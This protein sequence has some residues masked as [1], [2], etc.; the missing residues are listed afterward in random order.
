MDKETHKEVLQKF[1]RLDKPKRKAPA[2]NTKPEKIE[3]RQKRSVNSGERQPPVKK[4]FKGPSSKEI[5]KEVVETSS[6]EKESFHSDGDS[7]DNIVSNTG[8]LDR[9]ADLD[10][11]GSFASDDDSNWEVPVEAQTWRSYYLNR[12][13]STNVR[14]HY[15]ANFHKFLLHVGGSLSQEQ[16]LIHVRQVRQVHKILEHLDPGGSDLAC[17][18]RNQSLD[19]WD[20]FASPMMQSKALTGNTMKLYIRSLEMFLKFIWSNLF[21]KVP[22]PSEQKFKIVKLLERLPNYRSTIHCRTASQSTTRKVEETFSRMTTDDLQNLENTELTKSAIKLIGVSTEG[23]VVDM[24]EF[25]LVCDYLMVTMPIENGSQPGLLETAKL[26]RFKRATYVEAEEKYTLLVDEHKTTRHQGP[27]ELTMDKRIYSYVKIY[28]YYIRPAFVESAAD[29]LFINTRGQHFQKGTIGKHVPEFFKKA[30]IRCDIR[31]TPTRVCKFYETA[32]NQSLN[33]RDQQLVADHLNHQIKTARQ[34]Y[35]DKVNA[36]K[37]SRAHRVLKSLVHPQSSVTITKAASTEE[38]TQEQTQPDEEDQNVQQEESTEDEEDLQVA[39]L[40][41]EE[42]VVVMSI[43]N[44][45]ISMGRILT[46][47]EVRHKMKSEKALRKFVVDAGKVKKIADFV[48]Y[49]T[50]TV[51]QTA[52]TN[53]PDETEEQTSL[54]VSSGHGEWNCN[55]VE[56]IN[57]FFAS[58]F[59]M[60]SKKEV[61]TLFE[62][63]V[64]TSKRRFTKVLRKGEELLQEE[65]HKVVP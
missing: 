26:S 45:T 16:I 21:I 13:S 29:A 33:T 65:G 63:D 44:D 10:E 41:T 60:P 37:A 25:A 30:G 2:S 24:I 32:S 47:A 35:V 12:E 61:I 17:L 20:N 4:K 34:N 52:L 18:E 6:D 27:A 40:M 19:V 49:N 64:H 48:R 31:V 62:K 56:V 11:G 15:V 55:D 43:F 51:K 50:Q 39:G 38:K 28:A 8:T 9:E 46:M 42:K 1:K 59:N 53:L 7:D 58:Y 54:T 36:V 23:H 22:L 14:E 3:S 57:S 5:V